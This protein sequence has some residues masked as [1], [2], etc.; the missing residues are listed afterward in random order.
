[1]I[2]TST[3]FLSKC[4]LSSSSRSAT[5]L[6]SSCCPTQFAARFS[7]ATIGSVKQLSTLATSQSQPVVGTDFSIPP[8]T[9]RE[10]KPKLQKIVTTKPQYQN[11]SKQVNVPIPSSVLSSVKDH[12]YRLARSEDHL[13]ITWPGSF[14]YSAVARRIEAY[15]CFE[16]GSSFSFLNEW[17]RD[18]CICAQCLHPETQQRQYHTA[19]VCTRSSF[20]VAAIGF[21]QI[22][23]W[24]PQ[25]ETKLLNATITFS[26]TSLPST[27]KLTLLTS[28]EEF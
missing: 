5:R 12:E 26:E 9:S 16:D 19:V 11:P 6:V 2:G 14:L 22:A 7:S 18:N 23:W 28:M 27:K 20:F 8:V 4:Y 1:M 21:I 24:I 17:L 3:R 15:L 25:G 13:E 10:S